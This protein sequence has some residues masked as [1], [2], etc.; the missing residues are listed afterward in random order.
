MIKTYEDLEPYL[1]EH[2]F[3][4]LMQLKA[5]NKMPRSRKDTIPCQTAAEF[6]WKNICYAFYTEGKCQTDWGVTYQRLKSN[7]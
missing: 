2:E 7:Y 1:E 4:D 6:I 3:E 5:N